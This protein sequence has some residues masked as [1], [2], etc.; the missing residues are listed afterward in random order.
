[1][2]NFRISVSVA[3]LA[4]ALL[5]GLE[6]K[7]DLTSSLDHQGKP[8]L[9]SVGPLAFAPDGILLV[10]DTRGAAVFAIATKDTSASQVRGRFVVNDLRSRVAAL[11][12][13]M[14]KNILINDMAVNPVSGKAYLS[15]SRGRGPDAIPVLLRVDQNGKFEH[16]DLENVKYSKADLLNVPKSKQTRRGDP[17]QSSI[18]DLSYL[19]GAVIVAGLSNEE[20]ASKL[21]MIAFP[22]ANAARGA[23][24]EIYHGSHG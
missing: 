19:D 8:D 11:L 10:G 17:R 15:V 1:M 6:A 4:A 9:K 5:V 24:V 16:F 14:A 3:T 2:L 21:R 22:F 12:G 18:T 7:A 20:F 23:S 13:T